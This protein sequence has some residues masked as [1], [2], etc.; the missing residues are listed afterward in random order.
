MYL[1][2]KPQ[3]RTLQ[4]EGKIKSVIFIQLDYSNHYIYLNLNLFLNVDIIINP[5]KKINNKTHDSYS[6]YM[7]NENPSNLNSI[8]RDRTFM[9][10]AL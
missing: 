3:E 8:P 1:S 10:R 6:L 4:V 7:I 9:A 2:V 5:N